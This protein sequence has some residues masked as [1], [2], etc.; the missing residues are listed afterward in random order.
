MSYMLYENAS[1]DRYNDGTMRNYSCMTDENLIGSYGNK[2]AF[3]QLPINLW[4]SM[5]VGTYGGK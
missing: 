1:E 4:R 3:W 5:F 2:S